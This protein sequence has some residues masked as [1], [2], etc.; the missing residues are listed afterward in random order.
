MFEND[1]VTNMAHQL[2]FFETV[3][4]LDTYLGMPAR[5]QA[6]TISDVARVAA[7]TLTASNRTV[8]WFVPE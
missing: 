4:S 8:G 3:S 6:V 2:G 7:T 1:S 5:I